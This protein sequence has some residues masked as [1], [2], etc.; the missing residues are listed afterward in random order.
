M[1]AFLDWIAAGLAFL[2]AHS[3]SDPYH[4]SAAYLEMLG[5]E[6]VTLGHR[7]EVWRDGRFQQHLTGAMRWALGP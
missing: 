2:G 5:G 4:D 6:F 1:T 3:A 7:D